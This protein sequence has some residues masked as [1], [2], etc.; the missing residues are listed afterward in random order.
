MDWK[1]VKYSHLM[2][3]NLLRSSNLMSLWW[4]LLKPFNKSVNKRVLFPQPPTMLISWNVM[5]LPDLLSTIENSLNNV[6]MVFCIL[7]V[8]LTMLF[9]QHHIAKC[10]TKWWCC[11]I[12]CIKSYASNA[13]IIS[14]W[15]NVHST[16]ITLIYF[17]IHIVRLSC[18]LCLCIQVT[19]NHVVF[20]SFLF[21]LN[22][23]CKVLHEDLCTST[24]T[25]W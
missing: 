19:Q 10:S 18:F 22:L 2:T 9:H 12:Q 4:W 3:L 20:L 21:K 23:K 8:L 17:S 24:Q 11:F 25:N 15:A 13:I 6:H 5:S 7:V 14:I 16:E 1:K